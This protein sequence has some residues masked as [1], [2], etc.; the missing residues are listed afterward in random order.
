MMPKIT[1]N[2]LDYLNI[3]PPLL[4]LLVWK[5]DLD[6]WPSF[7]CRDVGFPYPGGA[8]RRPL[9]VEITRVYDLKT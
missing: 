6:H 1:N 7:K 4:I 9:C 8:F 3:W 5:F 2:Q